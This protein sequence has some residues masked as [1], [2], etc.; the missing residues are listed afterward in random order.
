MDDVFSLFHN[1]IRVN[2]FVSGFLIGDVLSPKKNFD[3]IT[4]QERN[5]AFIVF[6]NNCFLSFVALIS[7]T[8]DHPFLKH[9]FL[10]GSLCAPLFSSLSPSSTFLRSETI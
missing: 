10:Q 1:Q 4:D 5:F 6:L 9:T 3:E 2:F 8:K 7:T